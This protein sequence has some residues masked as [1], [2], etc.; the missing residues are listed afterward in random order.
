ML[1]LHKISKSFAGVSVLSDIN[2]TIEQG[3]I[4]CLLGPSGCG[5]TTLLRII[6]GLERADTGDLLLGSESVVDLPPHE[7]GFGL[8]F[9]DFALFPHMNVAQ[10][11]MFG[12]RMSGVEKSKQLERMREVLA[13]VGLSDFEKRDVSKLSGGEKQRV[14][15]ARSLA[16]NPPLLMLDEPLGS[17]DAALRDRLLVDLRDII[18]RV[19]LT[20]VYVTHDQREAFAVADRIV[21]MNRGH[22]EQVDTPESLY[23]YPK[24]SFVASFLGLNNVVPVTHQYEDRV[25]TPLGD[26]KVTAGVRPKTILIH[27]NG[28][29]WANNAHKDIASLTGNVLESVFQGD[30]YRLVV[31]HQSGIKLGMKI[32]PHE[33]KPIE[34]GDEVSFIIQPTAVVPLEA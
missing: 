27:P 24:T 32:T 11:I 31:E 22:I 16:P 33:G 4:I 2:L 3:E 30:A 17:L 6:A 29:L 21:V 14:A 20:A 1:K 19:S 9:Q 26:F 28:M 34:I 7:R 10:N 13:L 23:L 8:M 5:K 12:L 18:K 25:S 15:L